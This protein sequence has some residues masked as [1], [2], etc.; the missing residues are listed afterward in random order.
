MQE[1]YMSLQEDE[2]IARILKHKKRLGGD[3]KILGHFYQ[4]EGIVRLA[5]YEG[6]SLQLAKAGSDT[7]AKFIVFCGVY[8]MAEASSILAKEWQRVFIPDPTAG[9]PLADFASVDQV[10]AAWQVLS[11]LN[12]SSN[13][14]PIVYM[15]SS[16]ELKAFC[17]RNG[18]LVCTSSSAGKAFRW[19][20]EQNKKIF[21]FPDEN[22]GRNAAR[23][24]G[25]HESATFL[26]DP[27]LK[28][29]SFDVNSLLEKKLTL[30]KGHCH[31]H[32][33]FTVEHVEAVRRAHKGCEVIVHP[34]CSP[35]VVMAADGAGST[36]YLKEFVENARSGS[37]IA[38]GTEINMVSRL[39]N[40]HPDKNIIPLARSLCPNMMKI[41]LGDLL[42]TLD[43]LGDINEVIVP[44]DIL[45]YAKLALE[46]MLYL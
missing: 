17:G 5:D 25:I 10:E 14:I 24:F 31:I 35:S 15:N 19:A 29:S 39:A 12:I 22:L 38:I 41:G 36:G 44:E 23:D 6:D 20:L 32:T 26:W 16:A 8:F 45:K 40:L 37:T 11:D 1:K 2:L 34:E 3:L 28:M 33:F 13:F 21:F 30:W 43:R 46:R 27:H 18:G 7:D 42:M 4:R 9:C